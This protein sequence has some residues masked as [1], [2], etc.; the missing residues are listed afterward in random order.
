MSRF[1][2]L[3]VLS[4]LLDTLALVSM[5]PLETRYIWSFVEDV[6]V[7]YMHVIH[8]VLLGRI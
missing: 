8:V 1:V 7:K 5:L 3:S 2:V 4:V 6:Q